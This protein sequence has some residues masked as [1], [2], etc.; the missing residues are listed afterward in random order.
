MKILRNKFLIGILCIVI[1]V[2]VG[3]V[4]LPRSQDAD[5]SMTKVVR[6]RQDVEAGAKLEEAMMEIAAI[7]AESVPEGASPAMESF[8]N[9]YA[10]TPLYKGDILTAAKVRDTL[11]DPV[12]AAAAK[13][14]QLVSVTVPSLSAG[15][16][17][18]LQ[19]GDVVSI[20]V[21][22]KVTQF[23]QNL[24]L[25]TPAE[26]SE[27][28]QL[29]SGGLISSVTRESQTYIPEE[30]RYLEVCK[31]SSSDG[32]DALVNGDK[33]KDEPNRLPVTITFY[34]TGEQALKLAEVEQN[35]EIHVTFLARGDAADAYIP[36]AERVLADI[37]APAETAQPGSEV[38]STPEVTSQ[39]V[40]TAEPGTQPTQNPADPPFDLNDPEVGE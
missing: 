2:T 33:N 34:A 28:D 13:G 24:G 5:I 14:K 7:P 9:R 8:L 26:D 39:P 6:L 40:V 4:L 25:L 16:S 12:A 38:T 36:R 21:T 11:V 22:S 18:T 35:G 32:T 31:V 17:G 29:Q 19:P 1:G 15:V 30:L 23:N 10:S 27:D 3:F 37:A 20:M